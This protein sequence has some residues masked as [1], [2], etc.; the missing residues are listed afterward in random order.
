MTPNSGWNPHYTLKD[1]KVI[2]PTLFKIPA[3]SILYG[4]TAAK[5]PRALENCHET[6]YGLVF[7][8]YFY[9][10]MAAVH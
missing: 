5:E 9:L 10:K 2:K 3:F 6:S 1:N 7:L 8:T 4:Y